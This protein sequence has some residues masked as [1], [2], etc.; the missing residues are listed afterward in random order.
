MY[1]GNV[2][3]PMLG[4]SVSAVLGFRWVF[5]FTAVLVLINMLQIRHAFKK[6]R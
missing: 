6:I 3:G 5:V 2:I 4:S 1:L